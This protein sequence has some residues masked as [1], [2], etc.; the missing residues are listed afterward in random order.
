MNLNTYL[1]N[2]IF[3]GLLFALLV[4]PFIISSNLF[5]PYIAGKGFFFRFAIEICFAL[6]ILLVARDKNYWPKKSQ[7]LSATLAFIVILSLSTIFSVNPLRSFWS[8]FERMEGLVSYL[9]LFTYFIMLIS[10]MSAV[11]G[12]KRRTQWSIVLHTTLLASI[13][14]TFYGFAQLGNS[15]LISSQSGPR[16]DGTFGNAAYMAVYLLIHIFICLYLWTKAQGVVWQRWCYGIIALFEFIILF[17]T[18]TRGA[19]YGTI[20]GIILSVVIIAIQKG[21]TWRKTTIGS[22]V[23]LV[24]VWGGL[25]IARDS[26]FVK[27]NDA[28]SRIMSVSLSDQTVRS[29]TTIWS[30]AV[31]GVAEHPILGWGLDNFNLVFNKYYKSSLFDQE[32]WFDRAHNVFF[33]WLSAAGILGLLAYLSLFVV[34]LIVIWKRKEGDVSDRAVLT[35]LLAAYFI[36][37]FF[38]FDNLLSSV[39]FFTLLAYLAT[40]DAEHHRGS[41]SDSQRS[42]LGSASSDERNLTL[43]YVVATILFIAMFPLIYVVTI[44]PY[45]AGATLIDAISPCA[46]DK[47]VAQADGKLACTESRELAAERQ[48]A[49]FN[50]VF[51]LNTLANTEAREQLL[52]LS[53]QTGANQQVDEKTRQAFLELAL[54]QMRAQVDATPNDARYRLFLGMFYAQVG[55]LELAIPQLEKAVSLTSG[56][57]AMIDNL[58]TLYA[59]N[60]QLDKAI[61]IL[62]ASYALYP[63]NE[64]PGRLLFAVYLKAGKRDLAIATLQDMIKNIPDFKTKGEQYIADVKAGKNP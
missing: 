20:I 35:G 22:L 48:I 57:Q 53:L 9:H 34:A 31:E 23:L 33:D 25:Y 3:G 46:K 24:F 54:K 59:Q 15:A 8:N 41:T 43:R 52:T 44:K 5:F 49:S 4:T 50:K 18:Q 56:K 10:L 38:V 27:S 12:E 60:N 11:E 37:N 30:M 61:E 47:I 29:R 36:H 6:W 32:Q 17:Y 42:N 45:T 51:E 63:K 40:F 28:L 16:V 62:K 26:V 39:L 7:L 1:R 55:H 19:F 58:G 14:M 21:G 13:G 64:E 2:T